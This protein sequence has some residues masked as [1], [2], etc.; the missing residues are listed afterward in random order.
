MLPLQGRRVLITRAREQ[1]TSLKEML[2]AQG[3]EVVAIPTIEIV[4]PDSYTALDAALQQLASYDWLVLTSVNAVRAMGDRARST[5]IP[6]SNTTSVAI[7]AIGKSTADAVIGLGLPVALMP[8]QSIAESLA[9][10][11]SPQVRDKRVLLVRAKVARDVL[12]QSLTAAGA[13]VTIAEAYQTVIPPS[14]VQALHTAFS[15]PIDAITFTSA[16]SAHNF[17]ELAVA[18]KLE[19]PA[20][21]R[22]ISI[23]PVT[24]KAMRDL[25]WYVN[26]EAEQARMDSLV[27]A[28]IQACS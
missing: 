16:S 25:G 11:L 17:H 5:S 12:P 6:L 7:A 20:A 23:G 3:A 24:S 13:I 19:L 28:V 1:S 10:A 4:P 14:S 8:S 2:E 18:A 22:K 9:A 26:A 15:H 21:L 27:A